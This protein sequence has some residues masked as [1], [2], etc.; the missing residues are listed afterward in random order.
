MKIFVVVGV[1]FLLLWGVGGVCRGQ[2]KVQVVQDQ[3]VE[4]LVQKHVMISE[5]KQTIPGFRVQL[6]FDSGVNSKQKATSVHDEFMRKYPDIPVYL[7]F[8]APNYKVRAG[9]FRTRLEAKRL[10]QEVAPAY[11]DAYVIADDINLPPLYT[12]QQE[13]VLNLNSEEP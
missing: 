2:G 1:M 3:R 11:P 12:S 13:D 4:E 5:A 9:D 6:F 8:K 10:L 7:S